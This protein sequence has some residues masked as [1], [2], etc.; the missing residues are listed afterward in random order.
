M[1]TGDP[2]VDLG[3]FAAQLTAE[4]VRTGRSP[5]SADAALALL[6][7]GHGGDHGDVA[8]H[9]AAH[10]L[11]RAAEPFRRRW[12]DWPSATAALVAEATRWADA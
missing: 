10:L 4:A 3:S 12:P 2:A 9:V 8:T 7:E 11:R 1:R 6:L 5:T